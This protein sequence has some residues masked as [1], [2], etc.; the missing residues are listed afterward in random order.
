MCMDALVVL[1]TAG[2]FEKFGTPVIKACAAL[3]T[4]YCDISGEVHWAKEMEEKYGKASSHSGAL[5]I[6]MCGFDSIPADIGTFM[7]VLY[8]AEVLGKECG[9]VSFL[10]PAAT[11]RPS[12]CTPLSLAGF[13]RWI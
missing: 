4:S 11:S 8:M 10:S 7:V 5:I 2:P 12:G 6:P 1:N 9:Q 13:M 3:G